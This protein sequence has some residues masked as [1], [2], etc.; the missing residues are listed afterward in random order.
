MRTLTLAATLLAFGMADTAS[1]LG[2]NA[3]KD[4]EGTSLVRIGA[5][6]AK[7]GPNGGQTTVAD[8]HPIEFL[9]TDAEMTF[10]LSDEDGTP[11]AT[12]GLSA[13]VVVQAGG[14]TET[15][16][17]TPAA[18]NKWVGPLKAPLDKGAKVVLSA[19]LHGH[20]LQARFAK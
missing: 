12:K 4:P 16:S 17:L 5:A 9:S 8:G 15:V 1:A 10:Y 19:K 3:A 14:K 7:A 2:P 18:P 6:G 13:R 11:L 20:N